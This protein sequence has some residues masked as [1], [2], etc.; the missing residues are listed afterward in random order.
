MKDDVDDQQ[1]RPLRQVRR[2]D[3]DPKDPPNSAHVNKQ[4]STHDP[5]RLLPVSKAT[6]ELQEGDSAYHTW[7]STSLWQFVLQLLIL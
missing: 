3:I 4:I 5:W 7:Q 2:A 1:E 6:C